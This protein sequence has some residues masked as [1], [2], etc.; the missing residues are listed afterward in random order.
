MAEKEKAAGRPRRDEIAPTKFG[1]YLD[2]HGIN[3]R[4]FAARIGVAPSSV[5]SWRR[6][7]CAPRRKA[8]I[9]KVLAATGL[10]Q[11]DMY[12]TDPSTDVWPDQTT[13]H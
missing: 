9:Q 3:P 4:D 12:P 1:R 2:R 11:A 10:Q 5:Y 13:A 7:L 8:V 6:G